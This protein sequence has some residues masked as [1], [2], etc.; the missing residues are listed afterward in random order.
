MENRLLFNFKTESH[1]QAPTP[2]ATASPS[3]DRLFG[4]LVEA[5]KAHGRIGQ[6]DGKALPPVLD[7]VCGS[8][9]ELYCKLSL[10][11]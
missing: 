7:T 10:Q 11:L 2:T 3:T 4:P 1:R 9:G 5:P 6:E 8:V